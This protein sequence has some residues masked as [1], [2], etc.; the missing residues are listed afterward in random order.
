VLQAADGTTRRTARDD[1]TGAR[2]IH[3]TGSDRAPLRPDGGGLV[4]RRR[5]L[6]TIYSSLPESDGGG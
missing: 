6:G 3:E 2:Q 5:R 1:E 4:A